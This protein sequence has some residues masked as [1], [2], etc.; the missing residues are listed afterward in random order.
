MFPEEL[1]RRLIKMFSF[2]W[3]T[4]LDPFAGSGTTAKIAMD[5]SRNSISYE[6]EKDFVSLIDE[7][8]GDSNLFTEKI[9]INCS[10]LPTPSQIN[11]KLK[12]LPYIFSDVHKLDKKTDVK[13]LQY[14]SKIDTKS[15]TVR[16]EYFNVR[17]VIS[18]ELM[19]LS[20]DL[21]IRLIG[22]R[23]D[24][25]QAKS[26]IE[27]LKNK[28]Q[29]RRVYIKHD[30]VKYDAENHLLAYLYL[31]NKTFINAHLLKNRFAHV[32]DSIPFSLSNKFTNLRYANA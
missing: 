1:P 31:D 11:D 14:G 22:I 24:E 5:L 9:K 6:I 25:L 29:G 10:D 28:C 27:F 4:V 13:K 17:K 7:R 15:E 16:E 32:D 2:P 26:A 30:V 21:I 3:E 20:N 23:E 19:Q 8:I 12:I 18:S